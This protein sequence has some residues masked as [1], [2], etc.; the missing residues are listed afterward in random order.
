MVFKQGVEM[1]KIVSL[2]AGIWF[3]GHSVN[4]WSNADQAMDLYL[5]QDYAQAFQLFQNTAH[6]GHAKS[7]FNLGVQY[8]RGQGVAADPIYAYGYLSVALEN[9]FVTAKQALK[10]VERRLK[11]EQKE[12]A[13]QKAAELIA[14]YGTNGTNNIHHALPFGRTY[15]PPPERSEDPDVEYPSE[16]FSSGIPGMAKFVF[17]IDRNGRARDLILLQSYPSSDF[18]KAVREKLEGSRYQVFKVGGTMRKF[19]HAQFG[20]VFERTDML[21]ETR[22]QLENKKRELLA[23]AKRGNAKAQSELADLLELLSPDNMLKV[24]HI[25]PAE[26]VAS[27]GE[28]KLANDSIKR[29]DRISEL[30]EYFY[31]ANY[32]VWFD[33]QGK[34]T[35]SEPFG[36]YRV[37]ET[38]G[39]VINATMD[40][41]QVTISGGAN[42]EYGPFL[43]EFFYNNEPRST[44][45]ANYV[46]REKVRLKKIINKPS[47][48]IADYWRITAAQGG[49]VN[50]LMVLGAGCNTRLLSIAADFGHTPAQTLVSKCLLQRSELSKKELDDVKNWLA[51]ATKQGDF[52]A[53]RELAGIYARD[54]HNQGE[55][56]YAIELAERVT[57]E[58]DDP[59]AYEYMA[60]AYAKLGKFEEAIDMQEKAVDEADDS[61]Y[62]IEAAKARL[63]A[64]E[65]S[66]LGTW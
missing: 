34:V 53:M 3:S 59:W 30:P 39:A 63:A 60:A 18:A 35:K 52:V 24:A 1:K 6:L 65:N 37:P 32:L 31:N 14:L 55:L 44:S 16:L 38:I 23:Q 43:A 47:H 19:G 49:D 5:N 20:A 36:D 61:G 9:G 11:P 21:E 25:D 27:V 40:S 7:Q 42:G 46:N 51:A 57:N 41:W 50:A 13:K 66:K 12:K 64:Y 58:R 56:N 4:A 22:K 26:A 10:T 29:F 54:S 28:A 17:D 8:L 48:E 45:F 62:F 33:S 15:N 2:L